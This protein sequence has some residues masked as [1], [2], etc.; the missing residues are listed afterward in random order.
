[1]QDDIVINTVLLNVILLK[2]KSMER[3]ISINSSD[4]K[5]FID[6][7]LSG[8]PK[9]SKKNIIETILA[10]DDFIDVFTYEIQQDSI[11]K[12]KPKKNKIRKIR[13]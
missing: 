5:T 12:I 8:Y 7:L 4:I 6:I 9:K 1:M 10:M 3:N 13:Y 2:M 11:S